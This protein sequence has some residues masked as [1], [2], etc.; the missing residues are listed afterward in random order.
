ML[1][2]DWRLA[3]VAIVW[4]PLVPITSAYYR[5]RIRNEEERVRT[6]EGDMTSLTQETIS[7]I[8]VVKAFG[9]E[10]SALK[11]F[12]EQTG[13][14]MN[15]SVAV[16]RLEARYSWAVGVVSAVGLAAMIGY[17]AY[18]VS[19][20]ALSA[21][22]LV[23]FIQYMRD[24]QGPLNT[25]ARL[26]AK[27]AK[28]MV[29]VERLLEVFDERPAV[30]VRPDAQPAPPLRGHIRYEGVSFAYDPAHPVLQDV[31]LE[32]QPGQVVAVVGRRAPARA[33]SRACS[34]A[35][36]TRTGARARSTA[37]TCAT[38]SSTPAS[39]RSASCCRSRSSSRRAS[40]RTSP[41]AGRPRRGRRS[42]RRRAWRACDEFVARLPEGYDTVVGERGTTLSG[43]QRQR[44]AIARALIRDAPILILDEPTTGLDAE[45]EETVLLALER[46]MAGRTTLV[47]AHKLSTIRR[48]DC[49]YVI[50]DGRIV[51][52]GHHTELA[53]VG[54]RYA[55]SLSLQG[56]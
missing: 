11:R 15:A 27:L 28:V 50:E 17:G 34:C 47:I 7:S 4:C 33:R 42:T 19:A 46:L 18:R 20:G 32:I 6:K 39:S 45:V 48:A 37:A 13:E 41:T 16:A 40:A 51:E 35:C 43:G 26:W 21:G 56:R 10:R 44:I 1:W 52:S 5:R 29:R 54:G 2:L 36:T 14:M 12:E 3:L 53:A 55:R 30:T 8:R 22:T 49:I 9:G 38:T 23:V 31:E 25:L 24:V